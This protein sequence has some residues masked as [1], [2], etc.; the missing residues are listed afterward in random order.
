[1]TEP[2]YQDDLVTIYHG[3]C[4]EIVPQI[5]GYNSVVTS[6]PYDDLREYEGY[7]FESSTI[8]DVITYGLKDGGVICWV[9]ADATSN[10]T[11]SLSSMRQAI[12]FKDVC[13]LN[14]LDTM[15]YQK[16]TGPT[17]YPG[18]M[19][20]APRWEYIFVC[21]KG[22]PN[23]FEPIRVPTITP[24]KNWVSTERQKDGSLLAQSGTTAETKIKGNVWKYVVGSHNAY[25]NHPAP[26]PEDLA[27]DLIRSWTP[28]DGVLLDPMC[29]SGTSLIAAKRL[30]I[31]SIGIDMSEKYCD[32]ARQRVQQR[33]LFEEVK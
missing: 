4:A 14:L 22:K 16:N 19:R 3:D 8:Q 1:M 20:Y 26:F 2:Y 25:G 31:K 12:Y 17:P 11:E 9:V 7:K 15:I 21:S 24:G 18:I 28:L 13:G 23:Y 27:V 33:S 29:G 30:G 5:E 6:P 32:I 10:F